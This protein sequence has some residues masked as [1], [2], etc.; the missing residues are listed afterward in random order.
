M[1]E[2]QLNGIM[3]HYLK[4]NLLMEEKMGKDCSDG[5]MA[6]I[7]MAILKMKNLMVTVNI[8]GQMVKFTKGSGLMVK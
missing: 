5:M 7:M 2:A 3:E 6:N 8:I 4:V 1:E